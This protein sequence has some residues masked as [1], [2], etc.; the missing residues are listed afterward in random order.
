MAALT[1]WNDLAS[2]GCLSTIEIDKRPKGLS[3]RQSQVREPND[4]AHLFV[5]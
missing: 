3:F 5:D 1:C 2:L 4:S